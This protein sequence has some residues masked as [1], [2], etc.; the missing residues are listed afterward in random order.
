[1]RISALKYSIG[2][3]ELSAPVGSIG[4]AGFRTTFFPCIFAI[5]MA[6]TM[7]S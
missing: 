2:S 5:L 4:F 6:V 1:M 7:A 3:V